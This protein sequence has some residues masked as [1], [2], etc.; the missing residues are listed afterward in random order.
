MNMQKPEK[1]S[2]IL[3]ALHEILQE[4]EENV[5]S[6]PI[7]RV[8]Q[9]LEREGIFVS[10]MVDEVKSLIK[11]KQAQRR[12]DAAKAKRAALEKLAA[13]K[14][15]RDRSNLREKIVSIF[16]DLSGSQP[17]LASA[18]FRKLE[19]VDDE[20]LISILDDLELLERTDNDPK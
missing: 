5:E 14:A 16:N 7:D 12:L 17:Q 6:I 20:D 19:E 3:K 1:F 13:V 8:H 9:E 11:K 15:S 4:N 18:F 2:D 10:P